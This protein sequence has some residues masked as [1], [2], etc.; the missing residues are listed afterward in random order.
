MNAPTVASRDSLA[1]SPHGFA[2]LGRLLGVEPLLDGWIPPL[3]VA[4]WM[5]V[6]DGLWARDV[7]AST[8]GG[9]SYAAS[10]R[11]AA[12]LDPIAGAR[13]ARSVLMT[14]DGTTR[15][16]LVLGDGEQFVEFEIP[17]DDLPTLRVVSAQEADDRLLAL[18]EHGLDGE[19]EGDDAPEAA[20]ATTL[21]YD[22]VM[23][24][25]E[26]AA[27]GGQGS[28]DAAPGLAQAMAATRAHCAVDARSLVGRNEVASQRLTWVD[29]GAHGHWLLAANPDG[30]A[31]RRT[32]TAELS[33]AAVALLVG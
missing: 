18:L 17:G 29:G 30:L 11:S 8:D 5:A 32:S 25:L 10:E 4:G 7:L 20:A 6:V 14:R 9:A 21:A 19:A 12:L 2:A 33:G 26:E 31:V 15:A 23:A 16:R 24:A 22:L 27:A 28:L 13:Q 3:S 1:V